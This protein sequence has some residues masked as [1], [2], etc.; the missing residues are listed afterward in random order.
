M[1]PFSLGVLIWSLKIYYRTC[2]VKG[3]T[4]WRPCKWYQKLRRTEI[5]ILNLPNVPYLKFLFVL[6]AF[7]STGPQY[8]L[9]K[10]DHV[11]SSRGLQNTSW[12][13]QCSIKTRSAI[14]S[15]HWRRGGFTWNRA[16]A[17]G[18]LFYQRGLEEVKWGSQCSS[19]A[20][21]CP[22]RYL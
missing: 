21:P 9:R 14:S 18:V 4:P 16:L 12:K 22:E 17:Q 5:V 2:R 1:L 6:M 8:A 15:P 7:S 19:P 3:L 20:R 13:A 11:T 10:R